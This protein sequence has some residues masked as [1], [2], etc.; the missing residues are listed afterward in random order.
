VLNSF[1]VSLIRNV[2]AFNDDRN[3]T[4][5][6]D[7]RKVEI[8]NNLIYNSAS[9]AVYLGSRGPGN[10]PV[11]VILMGNHYITGPDNMNRYLLSVHADVADTLNVYWGDNSTMHKGRLKS[12]YVSQ[13]FDNSNRFQPVQEFPF[14]P[15]VDSIVASEQLPDRLLSIAGARSKD[16][17][18]IDSLIVANIKNGSGQIV[19]SEKVLNIPLDL[20][21]VR[22]PFEMPVDLHKKEEC[23]FTRLQIYLQEL[24]E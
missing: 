1:N 18:G 6:G 11:D 19:K 23:G 8:I 15:S 12:D 3:P 2:M 22:T 24:L 13:L 20:P 16:R 17:D 9:H 10:Y 5:R 4:V 14:Q 21:V 7:S